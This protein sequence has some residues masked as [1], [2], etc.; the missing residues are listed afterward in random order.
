MI[1]RNGKVV[2]RDPAGLPTRRQKETLDMRKSR[3][4][5]SKSAVKAT[6]AAIGAVLVLTMIFVQ[7][8]RM[9]ADAASPTSVTLSPTATAPVTW[10]GTAVGGGALNA[11]PVI[12]SETLCRDGLTCDTFTLNIGGTAASWAGKRV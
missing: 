2:R 1:R 10:A 6:A 8:Q 3:T 4:P 9:T 11:A 7:P 12:G 5:G